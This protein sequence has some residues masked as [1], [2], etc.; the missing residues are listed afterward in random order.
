MIIA[1]FTAVP[2]KVEK[3]HRFRLHA[4]YVTYFYNRFFF[5]IRSKKMLKSQSHEAELKCSSPTFYQH[6]TEEKNII[7]DLARL[8]N[9]MY[10]V[11]VL[12]NKKLSLH[13]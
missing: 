10:F 11:R 2:P 8:E 13:R 1:K 6:R 4:L 9:M 12:R 5:P 7:N 3:R